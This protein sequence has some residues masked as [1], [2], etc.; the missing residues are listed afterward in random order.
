MER[1]VARAR[2]ERTLEEK[3]DLENEIK[4]AEEDVLKVKKEHKTLLSS[5]KRLDDDLR[6]IE[7]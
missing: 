2:G 4:Q 1:R 7:R 5:V 6:G 3:K